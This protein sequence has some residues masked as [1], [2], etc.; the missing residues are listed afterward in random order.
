MSFTVVVIVL[1]SMFPWVLAAV[2]ALLTVAG[3]GTA[4]DTEQSDA[5][6]YQP[7]RILTSRAA[8]TD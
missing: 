3:T 2:T 8:H 7:M 6:S 4:L 5:D 1:L